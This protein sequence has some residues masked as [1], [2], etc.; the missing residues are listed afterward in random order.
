MKRENIHSIKHID[1]DLTHAISLIR[2]KIVLEHLFLKIGIK[3]NVEMA[4]VSLFLIRTLFTITF[5]N[6]LLLEVQNA[7][8]I[9]STNW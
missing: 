3:E 4:L 1:V 8:I 9:P 2:Q 5:V 6:I 7:S